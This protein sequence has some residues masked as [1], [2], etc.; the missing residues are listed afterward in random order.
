MTK[1]DLTSAL[2]AARE[3]VD[4]LQASLAGECAAR[5][6]L[7]GDLLQALAEG[8]S[9]ARELEAARGALGDLLSTLDRQA[10]TIGALQAAVDRERARVVDIAVSRDKWRR[11]AI[12][13]R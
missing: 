13:L 7:E 6:I 2:D 12:A 9:M 11:L 4:C 10:A 5:L 1:A 3:V 8:E